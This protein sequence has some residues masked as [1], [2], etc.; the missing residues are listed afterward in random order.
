MLDLLVAVRRRLRWTWTAA[1]LQ[2]VGPAVA[3][4]ALVLVV[5]GRLR[6][7]A[8]PEPAAVVVAV[9]AVL[10]VVAVARVVRIPD[11]VAARAA[12]RGLDSRDALAAALEVGDDPGVLPERV[13]G[14]AATVASGVTAR[15][16]VPVPRAGRRL[17]VT[18]LAALSAVGLAWAPNA[19]DDVRRERAAEQAELEAEADDLR[20]AAAA[21]E[22][23][24]SAGEAERAMA[25]E[26]RNL[27]DELEGA[28]S[29]DEGL[30][31]LARARADVQAQLPADMLAQ[32]AAATGLDRSL[33]AAP[34][35]GTTGGSAA[36]QLEQ[37]AEG[38]AGLSPEDQA[39]LAARLEELAATQALGNPAA[40]EALDAAAAA[41]AAGD[42][43]GAQA[44]LGEAA[45]AQLAASASAQAGE[46]AMAATGAIDASAADVQS[47]ASGNG[48]GEQAGG[49][50]EGQGEGEGQG[51]GQG[52][53][54][55][56][57][58]GS[59]QG[60]G[61]GSGAGSGS[62]QGGG[63]S[64]SGS[65]GA[66]GTRSGSGS[67]QGGQGQPTGGSGTGD[68]PP[69][70]EERGAGEVLVYD[71]TYTEGDQL[72]A[73]GSGSGGRPGETVG[74]TNGATGSGQ[75]QVPLS[76]VIADYQ[77]RASE[78]LGRGELAPSSEDLVRTYFDAIA[79]FGD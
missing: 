34:L 10:A 64:P 41:L 14:R 31:A 16:A 75:V 8:W 27:A 26:L 70:G 65:V 66:G 43:A 45:A 13:R 55:G 54:S 35:P 51:Q 60:S 46:A 12:D 37:L 23:R 5:A 22:E 28:D 38:L 44:A 63:G 48:A 21:L 74:R 72:D 73:G 56:S 40:A 7:W 29:L 57:G 15:D 68:Q 79:G 71:P 39:A 4:A 33:E 77:R 49:S 6:P 18:T 78:A 59:G 1:T 24:P 50:G 52:D 9:V 53:G 36:E 30:E 47:Q 42:I 2:W 3:L 58:Q 62:G 69:A 76:Q 17:A 61:S 32:R 67:G 20:E 11:M 19:Q 25:E